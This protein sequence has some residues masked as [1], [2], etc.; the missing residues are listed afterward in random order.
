MSSPG[1]ADVASLRTACWE[2]LSSKQNEQNPSKDFYWN[3]SGTPLKV[4][5][6]DYN[7]NHDFNIDFLSK[8]RKVI[9]VQLEEQTRGDNLTCPR[10]LSYFVAK[11]RVVPSCPYIVTCCFHRMGDREPFY[12]NH[13]RGRELWQEHRCLESKC[14][15]LGALAYSWALDLNGISILSLRCS[16]PLWAK[17]APLGCWRHVLLPCFINI[18]KTAEVDCSAFEQKLRLRT[19]DLR[20]IGSKV[21]VHLSPRWALKGKRKK[22]REFVFERHPLIRQT[23]WFPGFEDLSSGLLGKHVSHL[24]SSGF[25]RFSCC[26][27]ENSPIPSST[28]PRILDS[29]SVLWINTE[30]KPVSLQG[31]A[32][33]PRSPASVRYCRKTCCPFGD[34]Y[35]PRL[36]PSLFPSPLSFFL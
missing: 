10:S 15:S 18:T 5:I 31:P 20:E 9:P 23:I 32:A 35:S 7:W 8:T 25:P 33:N 11:R 30:S 6:F 24:L 19:E 2:S 1:D 12:R 27:A 4:G 28:C 16:F 21:D 3:N 26:P 34:K 29:T 22:K 17:M 36:L 14:S 13:P